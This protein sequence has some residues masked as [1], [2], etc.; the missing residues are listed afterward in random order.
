LDWPGPADILA[1]TSE[2]VAMPITVRRAEPS[3]HE[4][5]WRIFTDESAYGGTLQMPFPSQ[6]TWRERLSKVKDGNT[7]LVAC[8]G[9]LIVGNAGLHG[10]PGRPRRAHAAGIGMSVPS[11][12][13]GKGVGTALM[14]AIVELADNWHGYARLELTV[15]TDNEAALA[16]Y[17]KFGFEVEGTLRAYAMRKGKL[18][19]T[20]T[21]ARLRQRAQPPA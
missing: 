13:Q 8:E 17:R 1:S 4:G 7:M 6:E 18:V 16:L 5:V 9:D 3:D 15:F 2:E 11:A 12:W 21:M 10:F 14:A 20:Y 19:D